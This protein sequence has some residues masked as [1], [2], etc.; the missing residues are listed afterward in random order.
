LI[1]WI[2]NRTEETHM[3][4]FHSVKLMALASASAAAGAIFFAQGAAASPSGYGICDLSSR[5]GASVCCHSLAGDKGF[6]HSAV[7]EAPCNET[8]GKNYKRK[9]RRVVAVIAVAAEDS[10]KGGHGRQGRGG[11]R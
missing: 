6:T 3:T 11:R 5:P 8:I 4:T 7:T 1:D 2:N 10:G 9:K